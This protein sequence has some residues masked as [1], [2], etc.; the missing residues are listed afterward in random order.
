MEIWATLGDVHGASWYVLTCPS[1]IINIQSFMVG[2][3]DFPNH[4]IPQESLL[5]MFPRSPRKGEPR[6]SKCVV[7]SG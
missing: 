2:P 5:F 4:P 6:K 1:S 7:P 3:F